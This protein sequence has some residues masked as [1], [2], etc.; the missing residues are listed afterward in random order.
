MMDEAKSKDPCGY[1]AHEIRRSFLVPTIVSIILAGIAASIF[2]TLLPPTQGADEQVLAQGL[3][4]LVSLISKDLVDTSF[5]QSHV[6][7]S[8]VL[9]SSFVVA[10]VL[11]RYERDD[12]QEFMKVY[13]YIEDFY[14]PKQRQSARK[15]GV[16]CVVISGG[17][18]TA[19]VVVYLCGNHTTVARGLGWLLLAVGSWLLIHGLMTIRKV[20]VFAYNYRTLEHVS[21]YELRADREMQDR[22]TL[23]ALKRMRFPMQTAKRVI[24]TAGVLVA[25]ALYFLPSL[26]TRFYWLAVVVALIISAI[27]GD[28]SERKAKKLIEG[29]GYPT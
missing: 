21:I 26:E 10:L 17:L 28:L 4:K 20:D 6:V 13:P 15:T 12:N 7:A 24:V 16:I 2:L 23:I 29:R 14:T 8:L 22:D 1:D 9:V 27:L 3:D 19:C 25:L 18:I 11:L 5:S